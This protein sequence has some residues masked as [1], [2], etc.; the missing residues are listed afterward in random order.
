[1]KKYLLVFI[2]FFL[3]YS[4][5]YAKTPEELF[6]ETLNYAKTASPFANQFNWGDLEKQG[7]DFL[8]GRQAPCAATSAIATILAPALSKLDHHTFVTLEGLGSEECPLPVSQ[9]SSEIMTEW[10]NL[11]PGI[12]NPILSYSEHFHGKHIGKYSYI[13][14]PAGYAWEQS[15]VNKKIEEGRAAFKNAEVATSEGIILDFRHN[16]GGNNVPMLLSL[17]ALLPDDV[18]F[19]FSSDISI[20][21]VSGGNQLIEQF[22]NETLEYGRYD[23]SVP[24]N[25]INKPIIILINGLTGS[26]GAISAYAFKNLLSQVWIIGEP[27]SDTLSVNES[28]PLPDGNYFNLMVLRLFSKDNVMAPLKLEVDEYVEHDY[29]AM[30]TENDPQLKRAISTLDQL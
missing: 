27:S 3:A 12:K 30:F 17:S 22:N 11:D 1:M 19:K 8:Q 26:S 13:Y 28:Y 29:K 14:I 20:S 18:L 16:W 4:H 10:L 24:V 6:L 2:Y 7:L 25:K 15:E 5:T 23:G 21:L 9:D